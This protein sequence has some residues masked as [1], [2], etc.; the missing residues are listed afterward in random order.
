MRRRQRWLRAERFL[1]ACLLWCALAGSAAASDR[2]AADL[3]AQQLVLAASLD[4]RSAAEPVLVRQQGPL[5]F[6]RAADLRAL[7]LPIADVATEVALADVPGLEVAIDR[8]AQTIVLTR[9]QTVQR[10]RINDPP[11]RAIPVTR[12]DWGVAINYDVTATQVSRATAAAGL[13]D[14]VLYGPRG[15]FYAG[16]VVASRAGREQR[17]VQRLDTGFT[18]GDPATSRRL[19][20]GDATSGATEQSR[21]VR[22][23]GVQW[24]TD[25]DLRPDLITFPVP[26]VGGS[27]AVPSALDLIVNGSRRSAGQVRAGQFAITDVPVQTGV[28]TVTVAVRDALGRETRQT[29]STYVSRALLKPGLTAFSLETGLVRTGYGTR[30]DRYAGALASGS[31]RVGLSD[32]LTAE[33]HGEAGE[34]VGIGT[35]GASLGLGAMGLL[36]ASVGVAAPDGPVDRVGTQLAVGFERVGRPASIAARYVRQSRGWYDLA[37]DGG[38]VTRDHTLFLNLGFDLGKLG[39][40]GATYVDQ[41]RGRV[42]RTVEG[43]SRATL[44]R[45]PATRFATL[46][47]SVRVTHRLNL[48]GNAGADLRQRRSAYL[49]IGALMVFGR[50][51]SGYAGALTR[52]DG[53]SGTVEY[54]RAALEPGDWGYRVG[55]AAGGIDRLTGEATYQGG[56]GYY[57]AQIERTNGVVATRTSARGAII[58]GGAGLIATDRLTGSF[59][60]VDTHGQAGVPVF[61]DNR[62][63]GKTDRRGRFVV[64]NLR[65]YE[66]T[67]ISLDPLQLDDRTVVD[68]TEQWIAP[69]TR[70]GVPVRFA[71]RTSIAARVTVV[72]ED[73][74]PIPA[75]TRATLNSGS[76][77]PVGMDGE[78]YLED[79]RATNIVVL[80]LRNGG[81]CVATFPATRNASPVQRIGPIACV[82][83]RLAAR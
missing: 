47:Y 83:Q 43:Q 24:A 20:I 11:A 4:G 82:P 37:A 35:A 44:P 52:R 53:T 1:A 40:V 28:N 5:I 19:T 51:S 13:I 56:A 12:S 15:Y 16:G 59:A 58:V 61:R 27:A 45:L 54:S 36:S 25:F 66:P 31:L 41:G 17:H 75:G 26:A 79:L 72:G 69:P 62:R 50:R 60:V 81:L 67:K 10:V 22:F 73:G 80:R 9:R 7:G 48:V 32:R 21:P 78:L 2:P 39:N 6:L 23:A 46:T 14:G 42:S 70:A 57:T 63:V 49:S 71:M 18:T 34:R 29:V 8:G 33:L 3:L 55:A 64:A 77:A 68:R 38:A 76:E 65:A 30:S 74:Q